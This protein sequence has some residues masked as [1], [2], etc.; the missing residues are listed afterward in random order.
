MSYLSPGFARRF[1]GEL[2][3]AIDRV[4]AQYVQRAPTDAVRAELLAGASRALDDL[5]KRY[6]PADKRCPELRLKR[7]L[8]RYEWRCPV[9]NGDHHYKTMMIRCS[10]VLPVRQPIYD[11]TVLGLDLVDPESGAVIRSVDDFEAFLRR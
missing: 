11:D 6:L 2:G 7:T 3:E 4:V 1:L 10:G 8:V 9:C 5:C